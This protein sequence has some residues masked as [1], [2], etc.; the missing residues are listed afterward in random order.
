MQSLSVVNKMRLTRRMCVHGYCTVE[1]R[2][3]CSLD[4]TC[5]HIR[6][7]CTSTVVVNRTSIWPKLRMPHRIT[8]VS[9]DCRRASLRLV[10]ACTRLC[11]LIYTTSQTADRLTLRTNGSNPVAWNVLCVRKRNAETHVHT[12]SS[13]SY[14]SL[15]VTSSS[16]VWFESE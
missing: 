2:S 11:H 15:A 6:S 13:F 9:I 3:F 1:M 7:T 14:G 12:Q 8:F 5:V 16:L 4:F 10:R